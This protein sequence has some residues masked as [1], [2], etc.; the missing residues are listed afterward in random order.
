MNQEP[1]TPVCIVPQDVL[2]WAAENVC[3]SARC[4]LPPALSEEREKDGKLMKRIFSQPSNQPNAKSLSAWQESEATRRARQI[5][6]VL[7]L[8]NAMRAELQLE[9]LLRQIVEAI[10]SCIGFRVAI[11]NLV[12]EDS[13]EIEAAAFVGRQARR[14]A[15]YARIAAASQQHAGTDALRIS[16]EPILFH[17][18][19]A[20]PSHQWHAGRHPHQHHLARGKYLA[21]P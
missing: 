20:C 10:R 4:T 7:R 5:K 18:P 11:L 21:S 6:E 3:S 8:G 14:R 1:E 2:C 19:R 16:P 15:T 17:P 9:I 12:R 13:A